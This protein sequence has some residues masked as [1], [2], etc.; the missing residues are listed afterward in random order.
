M[1]NSD[2]VIIGGGLVGLAFACALKGSG[3][4]VTLIESQSAPRA[5]DELSSDAA[6][7]ASHRSNRDGAQLISGVSP[8]VSAINGKSRRFLSQIGGW[9]DYAGCKADYTGMAVWDTQGTASINFSASEIQQ[10]CLGTIV[11][12]AAI[13]ATLYDS[14]MVIDNLQLL[15]ETELES[16]DST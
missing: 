3:L 4:Q 10:D 6:Q 5:S 11:E 8:R 2:V 13:V 15:Y 1:D 14:A 9:P 16:V 12:N 7:T